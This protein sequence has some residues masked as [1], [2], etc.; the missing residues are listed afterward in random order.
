MTNILLTCGIGL[1]LALPAAAQNRDSDGD[2]I[3]VINYTFVPVVDD[4]LVYYALGTNPNVKYQFDATTQIDGG[5]VLPEQVSISGTV[6]RVEQ[7]GS[8]V[9]LRA[10]GSTQRIRANLVQASGRR[11]NPTSFALD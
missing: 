6:Y 9:F 11:V 1:V 8:D 2:V 3:S 10:P 4:K 5:V 7:T